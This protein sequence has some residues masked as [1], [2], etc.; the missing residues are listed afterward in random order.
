MVIVS[1]MVFAIEPIHAPGDRDQQETERI[2]N[3]GHVNNP[4][5]ASRC[6]AGNCRDG[7]GSGFGPYAVD[8]AQCLRHATKSEVEISRSRAG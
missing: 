6:R 4:I 8:N 7:N 5:I 2:Q 1:N 3:F